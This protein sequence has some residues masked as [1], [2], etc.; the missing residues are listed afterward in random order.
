MLDLK[1]RT[2]KLREEDT[3]CE[4]MPSYRLVTDSDDEICLYLNS[5]AETTRETSEPKSSHG[6]PGCIPTLAL[7]VFVNVRL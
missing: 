3:Y 1:R 7:T 2:I 6:N 4:H 5:D